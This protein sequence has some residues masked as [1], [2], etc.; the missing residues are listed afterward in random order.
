VT[1]TAADLSSFGIIRLEA[2]GST[3]FNFIGQ[4]KFISDT[5]FLYVGAT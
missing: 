1:F 2:F 3:G 5:E 4:A